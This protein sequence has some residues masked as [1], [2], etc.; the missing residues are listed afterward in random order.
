[1]DDDLPPETDASADPRSWTLGGILRLALADGAH[2]NWTRSPIP[3][4]AAADHSDC[5]AAG[6]ICS[7]HIVCHN[8]GNNGLPLCGFRAT[9]LAANQALPSTSATSPPRGGE[10]LFAP[11]KTPDSLS[12]AVTAMKLSRPRSRS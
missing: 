5:R 12:D 3:A 8:G 6:A 11:C 4:P 2:A 9:H 10:G 7:N 1:M